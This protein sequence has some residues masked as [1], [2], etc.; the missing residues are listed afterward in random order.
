M[1][2]TGQDFVTFRQN[3]TVLF[4]SANAEGV[5][6]PITTYE[7][8]NIDTTPPEAPVAYADITEPTNRNVTVF[9][10]FSDDAVERKYY[11]SSLDTWYDYTDSGVV[12]DR[13]DMVLFV[14]RDAAGNGSS[15]TVFRVTNID[16]TPPDA[17]VASMTAAESFDVSLL[18]G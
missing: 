11:I 17:P 7:V 10:T 12:L 4:R 3:G 13:N 18:S 16:K 6:S 2:T 14:C 5:Y 8:K 9:A 15:E 1:A